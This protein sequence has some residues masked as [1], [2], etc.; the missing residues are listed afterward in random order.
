MKKIITMM[1]VFVVCISVFSGCDS[2]KPVSA[3][4][5]FAI[6]FESWIDSEQRNIL[7]TYEGY[8]QK[9][10]VSDGIT[11]KDYTPS[12]EELCK[13]YQFVF[14]LEQQTKL[15]FSRSV[16]YDNCTNTKKG[17]HRE[18]LDCYY[19]KFTANGKTIEISGD[20]TAEEC[21]NRSKEA[22]Y[23]IQ[24]IREIDKFYK[25]TEVYKTLPEVNGGYM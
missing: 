1:V 6:H 18:P 10:L 17:L 22:R 7:D 3:P 4:S 5:D 21:T 8:I 14:E 9:D 11:K 2:Q 20:I 24:A 23:F 25:N 15:D 16:T 19:L 12:Y 13:L